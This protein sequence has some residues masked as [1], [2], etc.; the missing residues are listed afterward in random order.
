MLVLITCFIFKLGIAPMQLY[1][2][3]IYKGLPILTIYF[4]TTFY[5]LSFFS[6]FMLI[7]IQYL[8]AYIHLN[9]L[10]LF[11]ITILGAIYIIP[12]LFDVSNFKLFLAYSTIINS[13]IFLIVVLATIF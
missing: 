9:W 1:K 12:K 13:L 7:Y 10:I 2:L 5:F 11:I 4:Y 8:T 3:E 6:F